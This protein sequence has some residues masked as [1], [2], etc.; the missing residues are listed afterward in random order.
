MEW[1]LVSVVGLVDQCRELH[2]YWFAATFL[3]VIDRTGSSIR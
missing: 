2:L 1:P 3:Y